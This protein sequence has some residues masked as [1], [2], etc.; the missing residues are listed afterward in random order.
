M[1]IDTKDSLDPLVSS[2]D[3]RSV[4][5][6]QR[7]DRQG[8]LN[9][10]QRQ[11]HNIRMRPQIG[12]KDLHRED[13]QTGRQ[14]TTLPNTTG[15]KENRGAIPIDQNTA[16]HIS[17]QKADPVDEGRAKAHATKGQKHKHPIDPIKGLFFVL[18]QNGRW[19]VR[20]TCEVDQI[21][22]QKH[23]LADVPTRDATRLVPLNHMM[24]HF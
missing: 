13:V 6:I 24:Q 10:R 7:N 9:A 12:S 4:I 21:P 8:R 19:S 23:V 15:W 1:I 22:Q 5:S 2:D 17:I 18:R 3:G 16:T 11:T 20:F 14:G